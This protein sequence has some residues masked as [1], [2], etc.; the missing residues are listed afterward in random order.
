MI[1]PPHAGPHPGE[2]APEKLI[3]LACALWYTS[4]R[5]QY[6]LVKTVTRDPIQELWSCHRPVDINRLHPV[7]IWLNQTGGLAGTCPRRLTNSA[8]RRV[9]PGLPRKPGGAPRDYRGAAAAVAEG[10]NAL[11]R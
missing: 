9:R 11:G 10:A 1:P 5:G 8:A 7:F 2:P 3:G 4:Q 6:H